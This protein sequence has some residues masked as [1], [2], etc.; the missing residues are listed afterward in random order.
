MAIDSCG[1]AGW[2]IH[3]ALPAEKVRDPVSR[4]VI[5]CAAGV[6]GDLAV[7]PKAGGETAF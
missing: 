7:N 3:L 1:I 5:F 6:A 2:P 4:D